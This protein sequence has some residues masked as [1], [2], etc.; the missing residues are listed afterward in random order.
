MQHEDAVWLEGVVGK[1]LSPLTK[2][3]VEE[4]AR[5]NGVTMAANCPNQWRDA[6]VVMLTNYRRM[7]RRKKQK[8]IMQRGVAFTYNGVIYS[9]ANIT[10]EA[11]EWWLEQNPRNSQYL[12]VRAEWMEPTQTAIAPDEGTQTK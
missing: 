6:I 9:A 1:A 12:S 3:R 10:D 7:A 2:K 5:A 11:A 8:Y 4:L